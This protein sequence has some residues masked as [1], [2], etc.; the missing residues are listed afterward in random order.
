MY[1]CNHLHHLLVGALLF[2]SMYTPLS[3]YSPGATYFV[4]SALLLVPLTLI[5]L[6]F[7]L[8]KHRAKVETG[9]GEGDQVHYNK[10]YQN[11]EGQ[12]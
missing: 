5:S 8:S 6:A 2:N 4:G 9:G 3:K 12:H 11:E 7:C 1:L 10:G